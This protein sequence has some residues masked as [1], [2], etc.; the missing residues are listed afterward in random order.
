MRKTFFVSALLASSLLL[1]SCIG[2]FAAFN[3]LREWNEQVT[4]NKMANEL[5]F[6]ALWVIPVYQIVTFADLFV[7]N[8]MEFWEGVNPLAMQ[9]GEKQTKI[10]KDQ[11]NKYKVI[12]TKN[13]CH[14]EVLKGDAKGQHIHLTYLDTNQSWNLKTQEGTYQK[15]A[16]MQ[17]GF[18]VAHLPEHS[19]IRFEGAAMNI[20]QIKN[21]LEQEWC[22]SQDGFA[23]T[24]N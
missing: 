4:D 16:S 22:F 19:N 17:D 18:V 9:E 2:S 13:N 11:K 20:Q 21:R 15:L 8:A 3:N 24:L 14:I 1:N 10:I 7:L 23:E 12:V 6:V 5:I